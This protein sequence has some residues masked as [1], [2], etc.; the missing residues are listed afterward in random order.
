MS[1]NQQLIRVFDPE[2]LNAHQRGSEYDSVVTVARQRIRAD[3]PCQTLSALS[4]EG[5]VM[6]K[7]LNRSAGFP[8]SQDVPFGC[9]LKFYGDAG[10]AIDPSLPKPLHCGCRKGKPQLRIG[11]FRFL[12]AYLFCTIGRPSASRIISFEHPAQQM[13][14]LGS[15]TAMAR[16]SPL[17]SRLACAQEGQRATQFL[18][19][20]RRTST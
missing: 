7:F 12:H 11:L 3:K 10:S 6:A 4:T 16:L 9:L 14:F 20:W 17:L 13:Y 1:C 2:R 15:S 8:A 19:T 5:H 18:P